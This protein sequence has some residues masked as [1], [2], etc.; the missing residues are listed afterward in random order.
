[1]EYYYEIW[2]CYDNNIHS[3]RSNTIYYRRLA[4][5]TRSNLRYNS[6]SNTS[7]LW[8]LRT[9]WLLIRGMVLGEL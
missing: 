6:Y 9:M 8:I 1:M 7:N 3:T 5:D 4:L 2:D